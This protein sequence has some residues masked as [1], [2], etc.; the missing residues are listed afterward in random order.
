MVVDGVESKT[1]DAIV[2]VGAHFS[3]DSKHVAYIIRRDKKFIVVVDNIESNEYDDILGHPQRAIIFDSP[4]S[5]HTLV[6]KGR[7]ILLLEFDI[8]ED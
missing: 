8:V 3:P 5:L 4:D 1:C 6:R 2:S 7:D